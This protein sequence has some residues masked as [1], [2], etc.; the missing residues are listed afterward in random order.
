M[1][2]PIVFASVKSILAST[3]SSMVVMVLSE[4]PIQTRRGLGYVLTLSG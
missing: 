2:E 4:D 3:V 1:R